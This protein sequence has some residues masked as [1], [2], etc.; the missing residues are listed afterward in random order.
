M[1][2]KSIALPQDTIINKNIKEAKEM[3]RISMNGKRLTLSYNEA[4]QGIWPSKHN[5]LM[6]NQ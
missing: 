2:Q 6:Q 5:Y 1:V 3:H 4:V